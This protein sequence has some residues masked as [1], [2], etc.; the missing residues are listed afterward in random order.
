MFNKN[1]I[2]KNP[3]VHYRA[4]FCKALALRTV[5]LFIFFNFVRFF[6]ALLFSGGTVFVNPFL[7]C[8]WQMMIA[9]FMAIGVISLITQHLL[10]YS[11]VYFYESIVIFKKTFSKQICKYEL[12]F[13]ESIDKTGRAGTYKFQFANSP[14]FT[15]VIGY[16]GLDLK[17][18]ANLKRKFVKDENLKLKVYN[19]FSTKEDM[20]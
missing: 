5:G 6:G 9:F 10:I 16:S 3:E 11:E 13:L 15:V 4:N 17:H 2:Q 18:I 20:C 1:E 7:D 19:I 8:Y 12:R 14:K